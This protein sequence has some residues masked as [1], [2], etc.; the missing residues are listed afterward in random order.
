M[1]HGEVSFIEKR[2][3]MP[4][5]NWKLLT[6]KR[7]SLAQGLP[8]GKEDLAWVTN[9]VTLIFGE[10]DAVLVDTFLSVQHSKELL[11]WVAESGKPGLWKG[12]L[13]GPGFSSRNLHRWRVNRVR[14]ETRSLQILL[15]GEL[16]SVC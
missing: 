6:K 1:H 3:Y 4:K 12:C 15:S 9:T 11:D 2:E 14:A 5:P 8:P 10:R 16:G 7:G 13:H